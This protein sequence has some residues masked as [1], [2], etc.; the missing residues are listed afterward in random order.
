MRSLGPHALLGVASVVGSMPSA[1]FGDV[2]VLNNY[3]ASPDAE[4]AI[5]AALGSRLLVEDNFFENV[6]TPFRIDGGTAREPELR[7]AA[8]V[9]VGAAT[10]EDTGAAFVPPINTCRTPPM[11]FRSGFIPLPVPRFRSTQS[12]IDPR[13]RR[14]DAR[15]A[16][17][18]LR[19]A[20]MLQ[21]TFIHD[22]SHCVA[23][24]RASRREGSRATSVQQHALSR[25]T[26]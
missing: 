25:A 14:P 10:L 2:Q 23:S 15:R 20:S 19:K 12:C 6:P 8:N 18:T 9:T 3:Y 4:T 11:P 1:R 26:R 24:S 21:R 17:L 13:A 7:A 5:T 22:A 16:G